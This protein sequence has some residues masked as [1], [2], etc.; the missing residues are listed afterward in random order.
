MGFTNVYVF[1]PHSDVT[2]ALINNCKIINNHAFVEEVVYELSKLGVNDYS[3]VSPDNGAN[4]KIKQLYSHL[5]HGA[6]IKYS[7]STVEGIIFCD[8]TRDLATT[9]ITGF[10]VLSG[11]VKDKNC[12]IVDD[13][14]DGGGTTIGLAKELKL[15]GAKSIYLVVSH[16]IFSKGVEVLDIFDGVYATD[17]FCSIETSKNNINV[18]E[19]D[20]HNS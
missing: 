5:Y 11:E 20:I 17:S 1:D 14:C 4:K 8:K 18:C 19:L 3:L 12:I 9:K 6:N 2:P 13:I 15:K 16:G 7:N 10:E